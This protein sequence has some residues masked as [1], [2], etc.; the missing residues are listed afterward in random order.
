[1]SFT[2]SQFKSDLTPRQNNS[3]LVISP[4]IGYF[5]ADKF[6]SGLKISFN[7]AWILHPIGANQN[8]GTNSQK[9]QNYNFGPF[10]R[11]Y[12]LSSEKREN[13]FVD[14]VYQY[15]ITNAS[16]SFNLKLNTYSF[17]EVHLFF[18]IQTLRLNFL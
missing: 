18:S 7:S 9:Q 4:T 15:G 5:L 3:L 12:F 11:H 17:S 14:G 6:A 10:L 1:M 8:D 13:L 2:A 16:S